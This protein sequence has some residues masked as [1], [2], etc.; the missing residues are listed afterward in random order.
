MTERFQAIELLANEN[1][2]KV[3]SVAKQLQIME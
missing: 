3:D 1:K 2:F